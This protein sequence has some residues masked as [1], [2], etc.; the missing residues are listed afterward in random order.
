MKNILKIVNLSG[1]S[2]IDKELFSKV[3]SSCE[4]ICFF[5]NS[6]FDK[7]KVEIYKFDKI[8]NIMILKY[9]K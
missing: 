2:T 5:K 1:S 6:K 9:K 3:R 7:D 4:N 8:K